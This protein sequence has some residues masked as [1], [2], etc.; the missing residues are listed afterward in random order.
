LP[1]HPH[2]ETLPSTVSNAFGRVE[3]AT[4]DMLD[5]ATNTIDANGVSITSAYDNL[6]RLPT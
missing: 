5:R 4:F 1:F 6:N 2:P 3:S